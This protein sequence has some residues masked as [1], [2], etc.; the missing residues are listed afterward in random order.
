MAVL[1]HLSLCIIIVIQLTSSQ[2][3]YDVIHQ[4][5]D[6]S[7][8]GRTERMFIELGAAVKQIQTTI[9]QLQSDVTELKAFNQQKD[10]EGMSNENS[11]ICTVVH[12]KCHFVF[13]Y[14]S[15]VSW[16]ILIL[17]VSVQI[18]RNTLCRSL[19]KLPF[20]LAVSTLP[21]KLKRYKNSI[22]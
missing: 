17:F 18:G 22:F 19:K 4:K 21:G 13:D 11:T 20:T 1:L 8:C 10:A 16:S 5:N 3:T 12:K 7:S 14:N 6:V 2:S 15:S 9:Y